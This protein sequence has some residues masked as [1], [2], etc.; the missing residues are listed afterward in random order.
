MKPRTNKRLE[1]YGDPPRV[2]EVQARRWGSRKMTRIQR[3]LFLLLS[4]IAVTATVEPFSLYTMTTIHVLRIERWFV[5]LVCLG[6][7]AFTVLVW[8]RKRWAL[9][10]AVTSNALFGI[11]YCHALAGTVQSHNYSSWP[12]LIVPFGWALSVL[13][14]A[15]VLI[16]WGAEYCECKSP[17]T[18]STLSSEGAPSDER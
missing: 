4:G 10:P 3:L 11:W 17:T 18:K 1:H 13:V 12:C 15:G 16:M 14:A 8:R 2:T 6:V 5:A 9:V 7:V